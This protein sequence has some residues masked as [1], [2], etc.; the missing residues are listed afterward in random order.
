MELTAQAPSRPVAR[1]LRRV[2]TRSGHAPPEELWDRHGT[3]AY[4]LACALLGNADAASEAVRLAM[5]ELARSGDVLTDDEARRRLARSVHHHAAALPSGTTVP[6]SLPPPM[7]WL[8]RLARLQRSSLAL[9]VYG[10]LT[11]RE[12][13]QLL[14][15][16]PAAVAELI[17][18]GLREL[19]RLA[20]AETATCA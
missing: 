5:T 7:V 11:H 2:E 1:P 8:S 16:P 18:A 17:T 10:G 3:A 19:N 15:V 12:A 14:D 20:A 4:A 9:C 13:S 6:E